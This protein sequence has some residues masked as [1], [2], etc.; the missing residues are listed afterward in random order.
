MPSALFAS[1]D[2]A[3][4][5]RAA[6]QPGG[7]A[8][9]FMAADGSTN[10]LTY[11]DV[12][13]RAQRIAQ[14]LTREGLRPGNVVALLLPHSPDLVSAFWGA[15]RAG[16]LPAI[17]PYPA[18]SVTPETQRALLN[19][20][21]RRAPV[22]HLLTT[23]EVRLN[24][25][26]VAADVACTVHDLESLRPAGDER[27]GLPQEPSAA[28]SLAYVQ[29]SSGTTGPQK[30]I[31]LGHTAVLNNIRAITQAV[32]LRP[33]DVIVSWLPLHHDINSVPSPG[34][35]RNPGGAD[36]TV[37]MGQGSRPAVSRHSRASS[38]DLLD[39]QLRL[40]PLRERAARSRAKRT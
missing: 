18:A 16:V 9:L 33:E 39:A 36:F 1:L 19:S 17:L 4:A 10:S 26:P 31:V 7:Q 32:E 2:V 37:G 15:M 22:H 5:E 14:G 21:T 3:L 25:V 8:L 30:G 23:P 27:L 35:D 29:F 11:A 40:Q 24:L 34:G 20:L 13:N 28:G 6:Q 12:D 38:L